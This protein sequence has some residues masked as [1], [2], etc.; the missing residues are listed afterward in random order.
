MK[1]TAIVVVDDGD[2]RRGA[3]ILSTAICFMHPLSMIALMMMM[4]M[5]SSFYMALF[6]LRPLESYI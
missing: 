3:L 6:C 1:L 5:I 2:R 4:M